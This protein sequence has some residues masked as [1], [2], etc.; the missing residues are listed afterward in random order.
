MEPAKKD[1]TR[2]HSSTSEEE[3]ETASNANSKHNFPS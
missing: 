3:E 2:I 1:K